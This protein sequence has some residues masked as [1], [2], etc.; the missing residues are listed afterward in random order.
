MYYRILLKAYLVLLLLSSNGI[1]LYA[2]RVHYNNY[3]SVIPIGFFYRTFH[4]G[5]E[6]TR[7]FGTAHNRSIQLG[8]YYG[9]Q[10]YIPGWNEHKYY[11]VTAAFNATVVQKNRF[12]Y[13][14]GVH[15][16]VGRFQ[17]TY[18][19]RYPYRQDIFYGI[20]IGMNNNFYW[21]ISKRFFLGANAVPPMPV[22]TFDKGLK[23]GVGF[24][25]SLQAGIK[26]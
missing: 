24:K 23:T 16:G 1:T 6:Y 3:L 13:A 8:F 19:E 10:L 14:V 9:Q 4:K 25:F 12:E 17:D 20:S 5:V 7:Y 18:T 2:Q 22:L 26:L 11:L 21:H 15:S